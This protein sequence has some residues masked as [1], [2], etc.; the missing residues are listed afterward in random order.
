MSHIDD[1]I[2][3]NRI[4]IMDAASSHN[5]ENIERLL[6]TCFSAFPE[7]LVDAGMGVSRIVHSLP[8]ARALAQVYMERSERDISIYAL[9]E[10]KYLEESGDE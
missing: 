2:K 8:A 3:E 4:L 7:Y 6:R 5:P 10:M 1:W 9:I